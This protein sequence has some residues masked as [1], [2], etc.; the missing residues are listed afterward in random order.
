[1]HS[2]THDVLPGMPV[3]ALHPEIHLSLPLW[4]ITSQA[5]PRRSDGR[6]PNDLIFGQSC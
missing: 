4:S 3:M 1:M 6:A 5:D 2:Q